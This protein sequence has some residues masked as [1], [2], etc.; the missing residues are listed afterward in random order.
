MFKNLKL[1][2]KIGGGFALVLALTAFVGYIGYSSLANVNDYNNRLAGVNDTI[3]SVNL[4]RLSFMKYQTE[5]D[6]K[7]LDA[8]VTALEGVETNSAKTIGLLTEKADIEGVAKIRDIGK[9][10]KEKVDE[11]VK[12][13]DEQERLRKERNEARDQLNKS[14]EALMTAQAK[15]VADAEKELKAEIADRT[16]K[17][18]V[19]A[20]DLVDYINAMR[21]TSL[22][23][24]QGFAPENLKHI[25]EI[26]PKALRICDE[27]T[28]K[29][30]NKK[31]LDLMGG[32]AAG[33]K[34][35]TA[36][37]ESY[38]KLKD[39]QA[40]FDK[41]LF[42][43][44]QIAGKLNDACN[45]LTAI[46]D[47][48]LSDYQEFAQSEDERRTYNRNLIREIDG[49]MTDVRGDLYKYT[50]F[51]TKDLRKIVEDKVA[52]A[53]KKSDELQER[54]ANNVNLPKVND[55]ITATNVYLKKFNE[56]A[57]S[58]EHGLAINDEMGVVGATASQEAIKAVES[59]N[60]Q[61]AATMA[62]A[63]WSITVGALVAIG[64]GIFL[65]IFIAGS[66]TGPV[67]KMAAGLALVADGDLTAKVDVDSKD[68]IGMMAAALNDTVANLCQIVGEIRE[69]ADQTAASGEEL[70]AAAQNISSGAQQQASSVEEIAA[71]VE[72]LTAS[73]N[74]VSQNAQKANTVSVETTSVAENGGKTVKQSIDGMRLINESSSQISKIIDVISQIANQTNLLALNAAIEAA[75]AGEHGLGFAVVADEVRKLAER[76]SQAAQEITQLIEEST[77]RVDD[78]SRLSQE[79]GKSL[80]NILAGIE[81]TAKGM[82]QISAGTEEQATTAN[83]VSKAVEG[84]SAITEEN[85][86]SAEE[87]AA[88]AEELSAQAQRMQ[89]LVERFKLDK[90][91][92]GSAKKAAPVA[93]TTKKPAAVEHKFTKEPAESHVGAL[94]HA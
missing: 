88:S 42:A 1:A 29:F 25:N 24:S 67:Q 75:S 22:K 83:E 20:R 23:Y 18:N 93:A 87:M 50:T 8:S 10:Y 17:A 58:I 72:E 6:K 15:N 76:S 16:W 38:G 3:D 14:L 32:V 82:Q 56:F 39:D 44:A 79:V 4:T 81:N 34:E 84:I 37:T 26:L 21:I 46:Q 36:I 33:L 66:I 28:A 89:G 74:Q 80:D 40:A 70:S 2:K 5:L 35:Y 59:Q 12:T 49:Y 47:K 43:A 85:S 52:L 9:K 61:M 86:S 48:N 30:K 51:K 71:S 90:T 78:G 55:A 31:N 60:T 94:Y 19:I 27:L 73:I 45:E 62:S 53:L 91:N 63:N 57:D 68:E 69:A 77:S 7:Y 11:Y 54:Y 13:M 65:S 64:I 92:A 41:Q